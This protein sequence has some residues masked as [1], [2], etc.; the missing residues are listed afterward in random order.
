MVS[1]K[2][3]KT[4][5]FRELRDECTLIFA[6]VVSLY[7][8][9]IHWN[10]SKL[11]ISSWS[12]LLGVI[13]FLPIF[14]LTLLVGFIDP[15]SWLSVVNYA[16]TWSDISIELINSLASHP[17]WLTIMI[18]MLICSFLSFL[19][20]WSFWLLLLAN[21]YKSYLKWKKLSYRK[22][23]YFCRDYVLTYITIMLWNILYFIAPSIIFVGAI[24]YA[25]FLFNVWV[26]SYST[27]RI[28]LLLIALVWVIVGT[29]LLYRLY[30]WYILLAFEKKKLPL[31]ASK[32]Y[33]NTSIEM[34][35]WVNFF[36]FV[37]LLWVFLLVMK[38]FWVIGEN[39]ENSW[40]DMREAV[41]YKSGLIE[42]IMPDDVAY[43]KYI[44]KH[45]ED[46]STEELSTKIEKNDWLWFIYALVTYFLFWGLFVMIMTSF[47]ARVLHK[48]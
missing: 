40:R 4:W 24:F 38:P 1:K 21:L 33:V 15:I 12:L 19:L 26:I 28:L 32:V 25:Y 29:F 9:F 22:N 6:D 37:F 2:N 34:T 47:Y 27:V 11:I 46:Y 35:K 5:F 41:F 23:H 39:I 42:N 13:F 7:K 30:F 45:Y 36:K 14:F 31:R 17:F 16:L 3:K 44:S 43:Y 10:I 8:N 20:A 48:K 18:L